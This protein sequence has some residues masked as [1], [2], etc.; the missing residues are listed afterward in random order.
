M[1]QE[2]VKIY[3]PTNLGGLDS[4]RSYEL[5][6]EE[7]FE[8]LRTSE[9]GLSHQDAYAR[10]QQN[11]RN[12][13]EHPEEE[14]QVM[15]FIGQ[16]K[17]P[18]IVLLL[19]S[20]LVSV[21]LG[22]LADAIG[23]FLAVLIVNVVGFI[24]EYRSEKSVEAL[25]CLVAH[26]CHVLRDGKAQQISAEDLVTGDIVLLEVGDRVPADLRLSDTIS[27]Q[28]D[29]S[30][31]TGETEPSHKFHTKIDEPD[32]Q[33]AER[34]NMAHMGTSVVNGRGKGIVVAT[35][36]DTQLGRIWAAV[37][38]MGEQRTPL[39]DKMDQLGK[40][41][42]VLAFGIVGTIFLLGALQGKPLLQ[43]FTIGVSLAVAA[44]PEGLPI[45]VTVTLALG[46]TRMANRHAI[47]RKL[48]AVEALGATTVICSDKTG[49]L[50][51][52]EM[53]VRSIFTTD[54]IDVTGDGYG[55]RGDF[56]RR[57]IKIEAKEDPHLQELLKTALLC[58]NAQISPT[59]GRVLGQPTEAALLVAAAKGGVDDLRHHYTR[60]GEVPFSPTTKWMSVQY[61]TGHQQPIYH[62]KG[63]VDRILE[64][65]N[66]TCNDR[67][68]II[69][70]SSQKRKIILEAAEELGSR[71]MRVVALANGTNLGALTFLGVVGI[72][73]P[74]REEAK[75]AIAE[76][77]RGGVKVVM[78]TGD[79]KETAIAIA[80]ELNIFERTSLALSYSE[81]QEMSEEQLAAQIDDVAVFYRMAPEHKMK[82]IAA[83]KKRGHI[84]AMT[85]DG[86]NDAP[87]LKLADIGVA[88]GRTGTDVSKEASEMIL[89][90]DN[91]ATIV[92]AIEEGKSIYNNIKNFLRFQLTTS[93]ATLSIVASSTLF[94]LPLPLTPI[95]IL[96]INIIMDGPPAQSLGVEP[97]DRDVMKKPPRDPRKPVFTPIMIASILASALLMVAGTLSV[98]Y[99]FLEEGGETR[100]VTMCFTTFVL[101][102]MINACNCRSEEKSIFKIGFSNNK[103]F[104][105]AVGGS[106][107]L[108]L[109]AIYV[110]ILQ[111]LFDTE[112]LSLHDLLVCLITAS[113]VLVLDE[114]RKYWMAKGKFNSNTT[115]SDPFGLFGGGK[116]SLG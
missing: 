68:A 47:V 48:P 100:A 15:K 99:S 30:I 83:F 107:L 51:K 105:L 13:L 49:T 87:A 74:P 84:V 81:L 61:E 26:R 111:S 8:K 7:V 110:P 46:V 65:C 86:V 94:G 69:D 104:S 3:I 60:L 115:V 54:M 25:K 116:V 63:A 98:F 52:N 31:L 108:Q 88:M 78:I 93:I 23:I 37:T 4:S 114:L 109:A 90:D 112:S 56:Y 33:L 39:Q 44:I 72:V 80:T 5:E 20:A 41:L 22:E 95:Q 89:V 64:R 66:T 24:Q 17:E 58:N 113:S 71:A 1:M 28:I 21:L 27:L 29:E 62:V 55:A 85:G 91:F 12:V 36:T 97:L 57:G 19:C 101:F 42:S 9:Q 53:T 35:G 59:E 79:A 102:Q 16:F 76:V 18:L 40:Q 10:A 67:G 96:W 77:R 70:L 82:I 2:E 32:C 75:E 92:A 73:D 103:F 11:G 14:S 106:L 50:T 43:M 6:V 34:K 38:S 45:V